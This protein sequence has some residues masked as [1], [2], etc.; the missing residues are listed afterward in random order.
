MLQTQNPYSRERIDALTSTL[1]GMDPRE[2]QQYAA[3]HKNDPAVIAVAL[4]VSNILSAAERNKAIQ[5]GMNKPPTVV[6][7][8]IAGMAP[9]M[10]SLP[11]EQGIAQLPTPNIQ[12]M[13]DGGIAGYGDD[14]NEGTSM[15]DFSQSSEPVLRMAGGGMKKLSGA[16]LFEAALDMEGVKDPVERAFLKSVHR[17]ESGGKAE[18]KTSNRGAHGAMQIVPSTFASVADPDMD[19]NK[20]LDNMRAGI[21]Y[22]RQGFS[23]AKGDP[24]LAGA[25]YYGG[26]GGMKKAAQGVA[27]SDP[28]NPN[29]PTTIGYGQSV[30]QR[31]TDLLPIGSAQ[32]AE[33]PVAKAAPA[34]ARPMTGVGGVAAP[35][36]G[37]TGIGGLSSL[38]S[39]AGAMAPKYLDKFAPSMVNDPK[40]LAQAV[41][42]SRI[43]GGVIG[44]VP[45]IGGALTSGAATALS[46]ATPEQLGQLQSDIGSDT[47]FAAAIMNPENRPDAPLTP[48]RAAAKVKPTYSPD[49]QSAAETARLLRQNTPPEVQKEAIAAAKAE[50]PKDTLLG[51]GRDD[52]IMFGLQLLAGQS[53]NALQNF[54]TAG[55]GTLGAKAAREKAQTEKELAQAHKEYYSSAAAKNKADAEYMSS[56]ARGI[57]AVTKAANEI[58]DNMMAGLSAVEKMNMS[59]QKRQQMQDQALAQAAKLYKI[60]LPAG[61][62]APAA[63]SADPLGILSKKG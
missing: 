10:A 55:I 30:A 18:E 25:Y 39:A 7:Q 51:F 35:Q 33:R 45:A 50:I 20:P 19:I 40:A 27:V 6:D 63:P 46:N 62:G 57:G 53:P 56:G 36:E 3:Q 48:E 42:G 8:Q 5:A 26:P 31:M 34:P 54:G 32:A 37:D 24:V 47:G 2:R 59:P 4:N 41:K 13:A 17:Q 16:D 14:A 29:A 60:E 21:R 61:M 52:V 58:F 28:K 1:A 15:F 9:A 49:D 44:A 11:E 38:L 43:A 12:G 22:G 23:A